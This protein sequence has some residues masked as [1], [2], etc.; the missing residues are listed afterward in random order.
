VP[1]SFVQSASGTGAATAV[2]TFPATPGGGRLLVLTVADDSGLDTGPNFTLADNQGAGANTY[3]LIQYSSPSSSLSTFL[4]RNLAVTTGTFTITAT[5]A[6]ANGAA[7]SLIAQE[8]AGLDIAAPLDKTGVGTLAT[9]AAPTASSAATTQADELVVASL[10]ATGATG[11]SV[12]AGTGSG[13]SVPVTAQATAAIAAQAYK[14]V[15]ANGAQSGGFALGAARASLVQIATFKAAAVGAPGI[16]GGRVVNRA[17]LI[18]AN[19]W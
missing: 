1:G 2:A 3:T 19:H 18:R 8:F 14:I 4:V 10:L 5:N 7:I 6:I 11:L 15:S 17:A 13:L 12:G 9:T 16:R